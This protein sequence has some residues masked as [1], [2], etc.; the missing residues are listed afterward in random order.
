MLRFSLLAIAGV[1]TV[2]V[3]AQL[4]GVA[5]AKGDAFGGNT[6][7]TH[8]V[9]MKN[10]NFAVLST[11]VRSGRTDGVLSCYRMNGSTVWTKTI[12]QTDIFR[13]AGLFVGTTGDLFVAGAA[14]PAGGAI[15]Y[16]ARIAPA[17]N[18]FW[19]KRFKIGVG[20]HDDVITDAALD[21]SNIL[22]LTGQ[23]RRL[24]GLGYDQ[25]AYLRVNANGT[26]GLSLINSSIASESSGLAI[27]A[28]GSSRAVVAIQSAAG[29]S[30]VWLIN[31]A[32]GT[33]YDKPL[34]VIE[35]VSA[36]EI[37]NANEVVAGGRYYNT[38]LD[39]APA[40]Q[41]LSAAG[42]TLWT[43]WVNFSFAGN[44]LDRIDRIRLDGSGNIWAAGTATNHGLD[45]VLM[46]ISSGG[47][48]LAARLD[49]SASATSADTAMHLEIGPQSDIYVLG[50]MV[51]ATNQGFLSLRANTNASFRWE[52][53]VPGAGTV[54]YAFKAGCLNPISGQVLLTHHEAA[55]NRMVIYALSQPGIGQSDN[56]TITRNTTLNGTSVFNNDTYA[57]DGTAVEVQSPSHGTLSLNNDGTFT[58]TPGVGYVG[59]DNFTY[60]I[61]KA[62]V[63]DSPAIQVVISVT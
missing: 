32:S 26:K 63:S 4:V 5:W 53:W 37:S 46:K 60:K 9:A 56:Y 36:V 28:N 25:P 23:A 18:T 7:P 52:R 11:V 42:A 38:A 55:M 3:Q 20:A 41:K 13:P 16:A 21:T 31:S 24:S 50:S 51:N 54:S 22:H 12:W 6:S 29:G 59:I 15:A 49:N 44:A 2:F 45:F 17:G 1:M 10:G 61:T 39:A 35:D 47:N 40:V 14:G 33:V 57:K 27:R 19:A 30:R 43:R 48:V 34:G 8:C 62:G 58:Y